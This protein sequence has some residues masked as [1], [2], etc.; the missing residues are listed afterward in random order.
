MVDWLGGDVQRAL[1][2]H[3]LLVKLEHLWIILCFEVPLQAFHLPDLPLEILVDGS[4]HL[5]EVAQGLDLDTVALEYSVGFEQLE[6]GRFASS[7]ILAR[8]LLNL[9]LLA[10]DVV[11]NSLLLLL[12]DRLCPQVQHCLPLNVQLSLDLGI[13]D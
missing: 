5:L 6:V 4:R 13:G 11:L 2:R 9:P 1:I 12:L 7:R 10:P 8:L 3:D